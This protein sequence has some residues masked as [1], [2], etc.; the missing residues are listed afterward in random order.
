MAQ[1]GPQNHEDRK[2]LPNELEWDFDIPLFDRFM[3]LNLLKVSAI[4]TLILGIIFFW[5][6]YAFILVGLTI[7]FTALILLFFYQSRRQVRF[8]VDSRG[9]GFATRGRKRNVM[10]IISFFLIIM[11]IIQGRPGAVSIGMSQSQHRGGGIGWEVIWDDVRQVV[12]YPAERVVMLRRSWISMLPLYCTPEN[13]EAVAT[14][15]L[16]NVSLAHGSL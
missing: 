1:T 5:S 7:L 12:P 15:S 6:V 2:D 10:R 13:Y 3:V 11:G 8:R 16:R 4:P 14:M 9:A